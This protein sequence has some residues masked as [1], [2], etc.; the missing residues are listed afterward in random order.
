MRCALGST[1]VHP[2]EQPVS[3]WLPLMRLLLDRGVPVPMVVLAFDNYRIGT[4]AWGHPPSSVAAVLGVD[5]TMIEQQVIE[6]CRD[7]EACRCITQKLYELAPVLDAVP[8]LR[9]GVGRIPRPEALLGRWRK[10]AHMRG[11]KLPTSVAD[12]AWLPII[13]ELQAK[14]LHPMGLQ[15]AFRFRLTLRDG[16]T[17]EPMF[18]DPRDETLAAALGVPPHQLTRLILSQ[19]SGGS[20]SGR[21]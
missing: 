6:T 11:L 19:A 4:T 2:L 15:A 17:L 5:V 16:R 18:G 20:L 14:G 3:E 10:V 12:E 13:K 1:S 8:G 7:I 9:R 21:G